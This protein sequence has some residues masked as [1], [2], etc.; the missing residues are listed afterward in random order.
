[1][2]GDEDYWR[3]ITTVI[4]HPRGKINLQEA[5]VSSQN[6]SYSRLLMIRPKAMINPL[7]FWGE[8]FQVLAS[9]G[10]KFSS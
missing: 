8:S 1:M 10:I 5:C 6:H 3:L 2:V 9:K 4:G 7:R